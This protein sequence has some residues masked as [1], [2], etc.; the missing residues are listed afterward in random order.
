MSLEPFT[1]RR[2]N[3]RSL[4]IHF[5]DTLSRISAQVYTSTEPDTHN[6]DFKIDFKWQGKRFILTLTQEN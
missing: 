4:R 2:L 6:K 1:A 3:L 5:L